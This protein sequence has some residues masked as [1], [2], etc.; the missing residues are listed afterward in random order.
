MR[1]PWISVNENYLPNNCWWQSHE[2]TDMQY[3]SFVKL[4]VFALL[5]ATIRYSVSKK[6]SINHHKKDHLKTWKYHIGPLVHLTLGTLSTNLGT[7]CLR[8][9]AVWSSMCSL[10]NFEHNKP[11]LV[12][13]KRLLVNIFQ[14]ESFNTKFSSP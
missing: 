8:K 6:L 11:M 2:K 10:S 12:L 4:K 1:S 13:K 9:A 5:L 3:F 14:L 7:I